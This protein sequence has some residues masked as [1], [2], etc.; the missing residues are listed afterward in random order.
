MITNFGSCCIDHVYAVPHFVLP[1][2]TLPCTQYD[3]YPGGK[4]LNQSLALV[5]GGAEVRHAGKI[6][7]D[8][9]FLK[10]LLTESGVDTSLLEVI[11]G[12]SGHANIQVTP[13]GENS[14][15][16]FGGANR[17]I[18]VA[19]LERVLSDCSAGDALLIQNEISELPEL[20][21]RADAA[22]QFIVFNAA[23]ITAEVE[24]YPLETISMF[25]V[26]EVEGEGLTGETEPA[27]ILT[28]ME[29]R[30]PRAVTVLTLG[31]A[32]A[33]CSGHGTRHHQSATPVDAVDTTAAGDTFTGFFLSAW[34]DG[35]SP[36]ACLSRAC[37]A[38]G[39]AVTR[40]GA[41]TS[42]PKRE[43]VDS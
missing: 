27:A 18:T 15:V 12:P 7:K 20:M 24:R 10:D 1:G 31:E 11:D 34:V 22:G 6:G 36:E 5:N 41:A 17:Q 16:L 9:R 32:G 30:F 25:I 29:K 37:R 35:A 3:I 28:E 26:N 39:I 43:E 8:G 14:I 23:P 40:P 38:A 19:D 13:E 21:K 4:G 33:W 2:E 42:I